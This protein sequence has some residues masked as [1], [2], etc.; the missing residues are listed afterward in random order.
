MLLEEL[1]LSFV[2]VC[3]FIL[4][5]L[6]KHFFMPSYLKDELLCVIV[7]LKLNLDLTINSLPRHVRGLR[8]QYLDAAMLK[9]L[10]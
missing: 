7:L 6:P 9:E 4:M 8:G 1:M 10:L 2:C 3:V 5:G